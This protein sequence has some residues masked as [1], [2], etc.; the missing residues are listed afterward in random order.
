MEDAI[1]NQGKE[2]NVIQRPFE[3]GIHEL[4]IGLDRY[5]N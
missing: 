1:S 3:E 4:E 5:G 2:I